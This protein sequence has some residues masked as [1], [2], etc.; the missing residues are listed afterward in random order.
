MFLRE[1]PDIKFRIGLL[2]P[3]HRII[4]M[5]AYSFY[6]ANL[7]RWFIVVRVAPLDLDIVRNGEIWC[8]EN[9]PEIIQWS[10]FPSQF[11]VSMTLKWQHLYTPLSILQKII[12]NP[13]IVQP[14]ILSYQ[15]GGELWSN[16]KKPAWTRVYPML[17]KNGDAF[18]DSIPKWYYES[19][20]VSIT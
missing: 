7:F 19:C 11:W 10:R 1:L 18:I 8:L 5:D 3:N 16:L 14:S 6:N 13:Y 17:Y 12:E 9:S 20:F 15:W 2:D 4:D